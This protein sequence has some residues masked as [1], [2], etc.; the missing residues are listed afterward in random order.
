MATVLRASGAALAG[1]IEA[2]LTLT[3]LQTTV[4]GFIRFL[5]LETGDLMVVNEASL[6]RV[7]VYNATASSL[8][9]QPV[10]GDAVLCLSSEIA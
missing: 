5:E 10:F 1:L 6:D 4:G 9:R 3:S 2:P 8:A 7:G